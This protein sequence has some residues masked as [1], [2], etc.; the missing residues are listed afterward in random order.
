MASAKALL[1]SIQI[2]RARA[3]A[4]FLHG[5]SDYNTYTFFQHLA[6]KLQEC[7]SQPVTG[8]DQEK[9]M[10]KAM[11]YAFPSA[12]HL[13]CTRHMCGNA[14]DYLRDS[15]GVSE[16]DRARV[17]DTIFGKNGLAEADE[18]VLFDC[19][20]QLA[21]EACRKF[22]PAFERHFDECI[23]PV[24][25]ANL[26]ASE[27]PGLQ[28]PPRS[29]T[30]NNCESVNHVLKQAIDWKAQPLTDLVNTLHEVVK[31]QYRE[32]ER[33]LFGVGEF[34]LCQEFRHFSMSVTTW[35]QSTYNKRQRHFSRFLRTIKPIKTKVVAS[36][37]GTRH[38]LAPV[39][40]GKKP[41]QTKR[42]KQLKR[43]L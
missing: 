29:W 41:R 15:I 12:A 10:C 1:L 34:Q 30:N 16:A 33:C 35:S 40:G 39:S 28:L 2:T 14:E 21:R 3:S 11:H 31:A 13:T 23:V 5:N 42:K 9:A 18:S 27:T 20:L 43:P 24:L 26:T 19:R 8:S 38:V 17:I 4:K 32:L 7:S 25:H 22:A 37:D 36:S 6:S